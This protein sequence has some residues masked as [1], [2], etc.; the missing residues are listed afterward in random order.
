MNLLVGRQQPFSTMEETE[1]YNNVCNQCSDDTTLLGGG[2]FKPKA[3][4]KA[5][6]YY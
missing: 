6:N 1:L 2:F 3:R 4:A 5:K